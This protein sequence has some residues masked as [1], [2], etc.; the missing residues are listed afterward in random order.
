MY[1]ASG[2]KAFPYLSILFLL[3]CYRYFANYNWLRYIRCYVMVP[4]T[5]SLFQWVISTVDSA[6][7]SL[8]ESANTYEK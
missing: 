4:I 7:V 6:I 1:I 2:N 8:L 5:A 3:V